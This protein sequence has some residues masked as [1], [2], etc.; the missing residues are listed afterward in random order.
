MCC[1]LW[2][3][4]TEVKPSKAM[5]IDLFHLLSAR[6][7]LAGILSLLLVACAGCESG[8]KAPA[9]SNSPVYN[10]RQ[11]GFRFL[12]PEDWLQSAS[13]VLPRE[14]L[15]DEVLLVQ[16]RMRTQRQGATLEVLC[17]DEKQPTDLQEYHSL[18]SQGVSKWTSTAPPESLTIDGVNADRFIYSGMLGNDPMTK[19]VVTFRRGQRVYSFVGL[20]WNDDPDAREQLRR[21]VGSVIWSKS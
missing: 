14:E 10:N 19:E 4:E 7:L 1:M 6:W 15:E 20:F 13:A 9:L 3:R 18:P 21:A 8:P 5:S 11:E 12:V 16:Y 17:F 2:P